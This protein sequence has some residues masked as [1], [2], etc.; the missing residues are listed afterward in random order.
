[1]NKQQKKYL[2]NRLTQ[3]RRKFALHHGKVPIAPKEVREARRIVDKWEEECDAQREKRN[4][5]SMEFFREVE[6]IILFGESDKALE[7][8]KRYESMKF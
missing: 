1:M 2:M 7:A 3:I 6:E 8:L 5:E 4:A